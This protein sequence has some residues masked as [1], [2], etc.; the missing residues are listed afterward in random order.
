LFTQFWGVDNDIRSV[1]DFIVRYLGEY[2]RWARPEFVLGESYG[3]IRTG[4]VTYDLLTRHN[5]AL[6]DIILVW[7]YLD[8]V[9]ATAGSNSD[10][11]AANFPY[12][13]TAEERRAALEGLARYTGISARY[14]DADNLQD[15][16]ALP[17]RAENNRHRAPCRLV[18]EGWV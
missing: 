12:A 8:F 9:T 13:A 4:G 18:Q 1:S 3:G 2:Q 5:V 16:C 7:P 17:P 14:W 15:A 11:G 6:N 10:A